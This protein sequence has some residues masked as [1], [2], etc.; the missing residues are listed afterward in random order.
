MVC[1]CSDFSNMVFISLP[2]HYIS[3]VAVNVEE[4]GL[5]SSDVPDDLVHGFQNFLSEAQ[6]A[7][8]PMLC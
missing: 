3:E 7:V 8:A 5:V 4:S 1:L 2:V 6:Q